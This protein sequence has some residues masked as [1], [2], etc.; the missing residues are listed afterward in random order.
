MKVPLCIQSRERHGEELFVSRTQEMKRET[1]SRIQSGLSS[2]G[3][4]MLAESNGLRSIV[5]D[6]ETRAQNNDLCEFVPA[7][8]LGP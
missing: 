7:D 8:S 5:L 6:D 2:R 3:N 1:F 4:S